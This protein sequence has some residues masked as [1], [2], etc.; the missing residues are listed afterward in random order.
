MKKTNSNDVITPL[1]K[2]NNYNSVTS[3]ALLSNPD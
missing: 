1:L 2:K 3:N